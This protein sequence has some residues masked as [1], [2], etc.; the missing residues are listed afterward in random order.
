MPTP[1][2]IIVDEANKLSLFGRVE[3]LFED[4]DTLIIRIPRE[5]KKYI[6]I[7]SGLEETDSDEHELRKLTAARMRISTTDA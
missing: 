3:L 6:M 4:E 1:H 2:D 7:I 5:G